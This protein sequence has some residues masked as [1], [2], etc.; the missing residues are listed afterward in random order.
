MSTDPRIEKHSNGSNF[1]PTI[2]RDTYP[3]ISPT[4]S[5]RSK[6]PLSVLITGASRGIGLATAHSYARSGCAR[7]AIAARSS[8]SHII[9]AIKTSARE[10]GYSEPDILELQVDVAD[11]ASVSGAR[12]KVEKAWDGKLDVLVS[13]AGYLELF[14]P[15]TE[16]DPADWCQS[17]DVNMKGQYLVIRA[18][19]PLLLASQSKTIIAISSV[20]AHHLTLGASA[21]QSARM[22]LCRF[23]EFIQV[24]YGAQGILAVAIHPGGVPTELALRLPEQTHHLLTDTPELAAD[25]MSWFVRERRDWMSGRY[26]SVCWDVD[27]LEHLKEEILEKDLLKIRMAVA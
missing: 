15:I 21:Y 23:V 1:T 7:I 10:A 20:G 6:A 9:P 2:H 4:N 5:N 14:K 26:L 12:A 22:A 3:Q 18:F 17:L 25:W 27:E 13:N 16:S 11:Q 8:L 24:E 19:L